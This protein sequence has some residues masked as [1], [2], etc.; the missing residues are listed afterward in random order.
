MAVFISFGAWQWFTHDAEWLWAAPGLCHVA[1]VACAVCLFLSVPNGKKARLCSLVVVGSLATLASIGLLTVYLCGRSVPQLSLHCTVAVLLV[2]E[3]TLWKRVF[4]SPAH[5][6]QSL[7]V[8]GFDSEST[9]V[10]ADA[11]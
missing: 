2:F 3:R 6:V 7:P 9:R 8:S 1:V 4:G 10:T 5:G 11:M